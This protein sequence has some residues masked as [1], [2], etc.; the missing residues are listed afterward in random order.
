MKW[1]PGGWQRADR[2]DPEG[3][4]APR[5]TVPQ[6]ETVVERRNVPPGGST[7]PS[8]SRRGSTRQDAYPAT[9]VQRRAGGVGESAGAPRSGGAVL[10]GE[11]A[12]DVDVSAAAFRN[13][14]VGGGASG[15]LTVLCAAALAES[16][17]GVW[18]W[19]WQLVFGV[20]FVWFIASAKGSFSGRGFLMDNRGIC[21]RTSGEVFAV[22]WEEVTAVGVGSLRPV[23]NRRLVH[24]E[25][26]RALEL[27]PA[28][29][30]FPE[31][32]PELERWR[33]EEPPPIQGLPAVRYRFY[34][35][36]LSRLP[37]RL[38]Q[39]IQA[40]APRVWVGHY[41]RRIPTPET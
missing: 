32:H 7:P 20:C 41:R 14:A 6:Q 35:P 2:V 8:A 17:G 40:A 9:R 30:A 15:F 12:R 4:T 34:L 25:R 16:P 36:A 27:F 23:E 33:V 11:H 22:P 5:R 24:P 38:E 1:L 3:T 18:L 10:L 39:A 13:L 26:R 29:S 31:R 28:D 21:P 37:K 19:I